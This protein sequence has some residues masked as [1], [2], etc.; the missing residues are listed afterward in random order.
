MRFLLF[1]FFL[2]FNYKISAKELLNIGVASNFYEPIQ[3]IK[4]KFEKKNNVKL[5]IIIF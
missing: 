3:N 5:K 4:Q 1:F 2:I